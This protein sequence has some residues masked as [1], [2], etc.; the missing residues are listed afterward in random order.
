LPNGELNG[1]PRRHGRAGNSRSLK[2]EAAKDLFDCRHSFGYRVD[3]LVHKMSLI[4]PGKLA[5]LWTKVVAYK[6]FFIIGALVA[7]LLFIA[8]YVQSCRTANFEKKKDEIKTN[9]T[10]G[11]IESNIQGN[12]I[13]QA[14][15]VSNQALENVNKVKQANINTFSNSYDDARAR[16]CERMPEDCK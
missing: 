15:N 16:Y 5:K 12:V 4:E 6:I 11:K 7:V 1:K 10:T 14:A 9:I 3:L 2:A 13:N 8:W